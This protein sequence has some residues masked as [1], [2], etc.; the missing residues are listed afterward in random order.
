ML[1]LLMLVVLLFLV[2][3]CSGALLSFKLDVASLDTVRFAGEAKKLLPPPLLLLL[4]PLWLRG[5]RGGKAGGEANI[6]LCKG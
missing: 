5:I 3:P 6:G 1:A 4:L 2:V